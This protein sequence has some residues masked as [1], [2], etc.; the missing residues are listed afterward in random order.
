[1]PALTK[2]FDDRYRWT[3]TLSLICQS[4]RRSQGN[5]KNQDAGWHT[6]CIKNFFRQVPFSQ[7][8]WSWLKLAISV[9][10]IYLKN[11]NHRSTFHTE[12]IKTASF[13]NDSS[14]T[15]GKMSFRTGEFL[16]GNVW[17]PHAILLYV[18]GP[19]SVC[20]FD[21]S[22]FHIFCWFKIASLTDSPLITF[23]TFNSDFHFQDPW[24][25]AWAFLI[26]LRNFSF[27]RWRERNN[28]LYAQTF[29]N[30]VCVTTTY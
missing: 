3:L 8:W 19:T 17:L 16:Q 22:W 14:Q 5:E 25:V 6:L 7:M 18:P 4:N 15:N 30:V 20:W 24:V 23:L 13:I 10:F 11:Y 26:G 29:G 1:M 28:S 2:E 12:F 9:F 21:A 27:P